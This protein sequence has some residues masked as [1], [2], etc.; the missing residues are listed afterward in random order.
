MLIFLSK[1]GTVFTLSRFSPTPYIE[2]LRR[3]KQKKTNW[4]LSVVSFL[5]IVLWNINI[6]Y[7]DTREWSG[8]FRFLKS[9]TNK[10]LLFI[11]L[12]LLSQ[13]LKKKNK[14]KCNALLNTYRAVFIIFFLLFFFFFFFFAILTV[15][16]PDC[17]NQDRT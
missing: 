1:V 3:R 15:L 16:N 4:H 14:I 5:C 7:D 6:N 13:K 8:S 10:N 11:F 9:T 2:K 17:D 12:F